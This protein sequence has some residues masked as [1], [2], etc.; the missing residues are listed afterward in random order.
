VNVLEEDILDSFSRAEKIA[1]I[2]PTLNE[3]EN[4]RAL[5]SR[6]RSTLDP[7][8]IKYELIVVDD[9]SRDG[10]NAVVAE[11][12]QEDARVRLIIRKGERGLSGAILH[13]WQHTDANILGVIDADFQHPPELL[14]QLCSS[15]EQGADLVVASRYAN[16]GDVGN[17]NALRR[18]ASSL[19]IGLTLPLQRRSCRVKDPMSGFFLVRRECIQ[20]LQFQKSGFKLLLEILVRAD[21]HAVAEIPFSF[22][23]RG[24][25]ASKANFRVALDY[26]TLLR[27]LYGLRWMDN[28]PSSTSV[29]SASVS[30]FSAGLEDEPE[31]WTAMNQLPIHESI[32]S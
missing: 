5:L 28:S 27:S 30:V 24:H 29:D 13:G 25:G 11:I 18:M 12:A 20:N 21:V 10:I 32:H 4:I 23:L 3:A 9:D 22:G 26:L 8:K 19:A 7:L 15:I 1:L 31:A 2:I 16:G 6:I 17:W 14:Q